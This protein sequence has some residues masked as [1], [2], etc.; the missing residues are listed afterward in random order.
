MHAR[1]PA[2]SPQSSRNGANRNRSENTSHH[3][4]AL[5]SHSTV[6]QANKNHNPEARRIRPQALSSAQHLSGT[7]SGTI[8][9]V[10]VITLGCSKNTA[11]SETL[12]GLIQSH[13]MSFT[14]ARSADAVIINTCGFIDRAKEESIQTIFSAIQQKQEL[15]AK[16]KQQK[17]IVAGCLSQRYGDDLKQEMPEVDAFFG[18]SDF[19]NVVKALTP[20]FKYNLLGDAP[21]Q[22]VLTTP[23]HFAYLKVS[24]GCDNP[25]SFCAIPLM[26]GGHKSRTPEQLVDEARLLAEKGV[27]ELILIAQDLTD[28]GRD[29]TG[30]KSLADLLRRLSDVQGLEWIRLM[31]AYPARFPKDILSVIAERPNIAK[32]LDIPLQHASTNVLKSMRRGITRQATERL[33]DEIRQTIPDITLRTTFII[34][35]P[36]ET[37]ADFKELCEFVEQQRFDRLGVFEY[38]QEDDTYAAILGDPIAADIKQQR[39]QTLMDLQRSISLEKNE[40]RIGTRVKA[41]IDH[42]YVSADST[43]EYQARTE[44]DAPEVDNELFLTSSVPLQAG[45]I[46]LADIHDASEYDLFGEA[47]SRL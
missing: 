24:E 47:V 41:L 18:E 46:V 32:Y 8:S 23:S 5:D 21:M 45:D 17:L 3:S 27:K 13:G 19:E 20:D 4:A 44:A 11:D 33:L 2:P 25:C 6:R 26:R 42:V 37:E 30:K 28:Y 12:M 14:D 43:T 10:S 9:T 1:T 15:A 22:R 38:S 39:V 29:L 36:N 35:Y 7:I 31:Y 40:A 34:G 16:G